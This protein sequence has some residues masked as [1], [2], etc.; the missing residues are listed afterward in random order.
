MYKRQARGTIAKSKFLEA[1]SN[2][3][4]ILNDLIQFGILEEA[5]STEV[6]LKPNIP[7]DADIIKKIAKNDFDTIW[8]LL[9]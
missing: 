7:L 9:E 6:R 4:A 2:G 1:C 5:S 8:L 3:A